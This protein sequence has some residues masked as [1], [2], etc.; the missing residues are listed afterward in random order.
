M[1]IDIDDA[2]NVHPVALQDE[3][4]HGFTQQVEDAEDVGAADAGAERE[5]SIGG[6]LDAGA[7]REL[8]PGVVIVR[9]RREHVSDEGVSD[10]H[11]FVLFLLGWRLPTECGIPP[12][13]LEC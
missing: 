7:T 8:D 6:L 4:D 2:G 13:R 1:R 10:G 9:V 3:C 5:H 12:S 11:G